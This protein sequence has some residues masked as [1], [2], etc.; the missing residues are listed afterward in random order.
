MYAK[1]EGVAKNLILAHIFYNLAAANGDGTA[2]N[3]RDV[4]SPKLTSTQLTEA[5]ELA[6]KWV[7]NQPLPTITKTYPSSKKRK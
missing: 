3:N 2:K 1:G 7:I 6:S 5:Q 4:L